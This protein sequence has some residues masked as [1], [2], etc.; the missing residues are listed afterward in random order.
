VRSFGYRYPFHGKDRPQIEAE[1]VEHAARQ[2]QSSYLVD[3]VRSVIASPASGELAGS[4][5]MIDLFVA[6]RPIPDPPFEV[7]S[8]RGPA[9]LRPPPRGLI[10]I[11]HLALSNRNDVI[12]RPPEEAVRLF[13]RFVSEKFG[14]ESGYQ[15]GESERIKPGKV[16]S[17]KT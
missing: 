6:A 14:V 13:W 9:S 1:V 3:I 16:L 10:R 15:N 17:P 7:I 12:D 2:P 11:E 5:G 8:I 4:L